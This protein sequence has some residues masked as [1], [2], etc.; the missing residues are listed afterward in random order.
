[1]NLVGDISGRAAG[2]EVRV[3]AQDD[4]AAILGDGV[5]VESLCREPRQGDGVE[6]DAGEGWPSPRRGSL[7]T[8]ST[9]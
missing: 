7:F 9:S 2:A 5:G 8:S 3:V 6:A 1:M 4:L